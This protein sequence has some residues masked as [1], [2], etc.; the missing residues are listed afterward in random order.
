M[1][2]PT[3]RSLDPTPTAELRRRWAAVRRIGAERSVDALVVQN[4]Q[5]YLGGYVRW[6]T[7]TPAYHGYPRTVLLFPDE[8]MVVVEQGERD[9][10]R[11]PSSHETAYRGVDRV[12]TTSS[13]VS[14]RYTAGYDAGLA[15]DELAARGARRVGWISPTSAYHGF[16]QALR[17]FLPNVEFVD[18]TEEIDSVKAIKSPAEQDLIRQTTALQDQVIAEITQFLKPG[19]RDFEITAYARYA[20]QRLGS[21]QDI[22]LA[23]SSAPGEPAAFRWP[24]DQGRTLEHGD[25]FTL[26]VETNGRGGMWTELSRTFVIGR[27][28][29]E[30]RKAFQL[31]RSAQDAIVDT[32]VPGL[33]AAEIEHAHN[34]RM[35]LDG[36]PPEHRL[37]AHGQGLDVVERPLVRADEPFSVS[38]G[39]NLAVHPGFVVN[40]AFGFICDNYLVGADGP[41]RLH[42]TA[43]D[44]I[45]V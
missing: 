7:G 28:P 41:E 23:S 40:G 27:A 43:R 34:D 33:P 17:E 35:T 3:G 20:A 1:R 13:F 29:G 36:L 10:V 8:R 30:L 45:E 15:A 11:T 14:A 42:R 38:E 21:D 2:Q 5:D 22:L 31:A 6:L 37:L 44:L 39:H 26:L 25:V 18:V 4:S 19:L 32:L 9:V 24:H 12:L 16:G